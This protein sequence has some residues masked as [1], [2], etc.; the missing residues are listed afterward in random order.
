M[1]KFC[2]FLKE[3]SALYTIMARYDGFTFLFTRETFVHN[4]DNFCD[5]LLEKTHFRREQNQSLLKVYQFPI[6]ALFRTIYDVP[7]YVV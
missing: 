3:L 5:F 4:G 2:Q 7:I 1:G 6:H